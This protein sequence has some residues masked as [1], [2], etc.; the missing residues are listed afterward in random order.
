MLVYRCA[1]CSASFGVSN[2]DA[3]LHL[4]GVVMR[5]PTEE[6]AG[7]LQLEGGEAAQVVTA[8]QLFAAARG[9]GTPEEKECSTEKLQNALVGRRIVGI[10]VVETG[11]KNR[12]VVKSIVLD[13]GVRAHFGS[14]S[15]GALIYKLTEGKQ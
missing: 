8:Q 1:T 14:S 4:L 12:P 9:F 10:E 13:D 11:R 6:C 7:R 5:C 15:A 2:T 3:H